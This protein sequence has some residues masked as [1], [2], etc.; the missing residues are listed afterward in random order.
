MTPK[1]RM[2]ATLRGEAADHI[3]CAPFFWSSPTTPGYTWRSDEKR[4]EVVVGKLG[5][6]AFIPVGLGADW[7][8]EVAVR[9]WQDHP[10]GEQHPHLHKE[11]QTPAGMLSA[12]VRRTEDWPHGDDIPLCSDFNVSR[13]VKPW[14]ETPEDVE[15]YA[16][17][18]VPSGPA[19]IEAAQRLIEEKRTLADRW[20]VPL[21][22]GC[23]LGL[24]A[25]IQ[26]FG[27]ERAVLFSMDHPDTLDRFLDI[28][29]RTTMKRMEA[30]LDLGADI[31]CR[32]G[33][34][35]TMDFWSPAQY[36]RHL[37]PRLREE[38]DLVHA[39]GRTITYTVC[40]GIMPMLP[41]LASLDFDGLYSIEPALGHQDMQAVADTLGGEK[42]IWG[43]V[44]APIHIG[45]GTPETVRHAVRDAV[46]TFGTH[47][48]LA[49]VPSIR[50]HWPWENVLAMFDEWRRCRDLGV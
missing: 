38:I 4:L 43:G 49:A 44:S 3:P 16:H 37:M 6:D 29:H 28:D 40:T 42:C 21:Y 41:H 14:L 10:P 19:S 23:G 18:H 7:S 46:E 45:E 1:E 34:Y 9:I 39:A 11:I 48:V 30:L 22:A 26:L 13:Y 47:L 5:L 2:L 27:P 33:F 12:T 31:I 17:V 24:T 35:E 32:N 36:E 50:A 20:Q 15:K 25:A 8:P